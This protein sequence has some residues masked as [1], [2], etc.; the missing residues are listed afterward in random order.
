MYKEDVT[1]KEI[2]E[3][4]ERDCSAMRLAGCE[5]AVAALRVVKDYDGIHRLLLAVANWSTV[6]A[7]EGGRPHPNNA[8]ARDAE[9]DA[10]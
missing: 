9:P 1:Q 8:I 3:F 5:L 10:R 6:I 7:N 4:L 2:I